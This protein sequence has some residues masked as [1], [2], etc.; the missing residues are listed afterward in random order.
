MAKCSVVALDICPFKNA[1]SRTPL[2]YKFMSDHGNPR[3]V[4]G[5]PKNIASDIVSPSRPPRTIKYPTINVIKI[6]RHKNNAFRSL[7]PNGMVP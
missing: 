5:K 6:G 2:I 4:I 3:S 7:I 1:V